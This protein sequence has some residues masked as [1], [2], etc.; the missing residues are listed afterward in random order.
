M[1][2]NLLRDPIFSTNLEEKVSLPRLIQG[3]HSEEIKTL[4]KVPAHQ[5]TLFHSFLCQLSALAVSRHCGN[6]APS[7]TDGWYEAL[8]ALTNDDEAYWEL[9]TPAGQPAFMQVCLTEEEAEKNADTVKTNLSSIDLLFDSK[10]HSVKKGVG[11][12]ATAEEWIYGLVAVQGGAGYGGN[13]HYGSVRLRSG[14]ASRPFMGLVPIDGHDMSVHAGKWVK[15]DVEAIVK[16]RQTNDPDKLDEY[17]KSA[18]M[19]LQDWDGTPGHIELEDLDPHFI[20]VCKRIKLTHT[21][22][23]AIGAYSLS[24]TGRRIKTPE[25]YEGAGDDPWA[26]TEIVSR[27]SGSGSEEIA[28]NATVNPGERGIDYRLIMDL[29]MNDGRYN[30]PFLADL[31]EDA[32]V[33]LMLEFTGRGKCK[34]HGHH[35]RVVSLPR[36]ITNAFERP[37]M[38]EQVNEMLSFIKDAENIAR[39]ALTLYFYNGDHKKR[40][41]AGSRPALL[42]NALSA[43]C[44]DITRQI[45]RGFFRHLHKVATET[46]MDAGSQMMNAFKAWVM[47]VVIEETEHAF[48]RTPRSINVRHK[49]DAMASAELHRR[50][51]NFQVEQAA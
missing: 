19:W 24:T 4:T 8:L 21:E 36:R 33:A 28:R 29:M 9:I 6:V 10:N 39:G 5:V 16:R 25:G 22:S 7:T 45:D 44:D 23:G 34:T 42:T 18:L 35:S 41:R 2:V 14:N 11:E 26:P 17:K 15:R 37:G 46:R 30:K 12:N 31:R 50:L 27:K 47:E 40:E 51:R 32:D 20:E 48:Q 49:A 38:K 1:P 13:R 3:L 43:L